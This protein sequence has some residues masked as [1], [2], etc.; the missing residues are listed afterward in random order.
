MKGI[1][2]DVFFHTEQ[3][4]KFDDLNIPYPLEECETR[5]MT[6][7]N[8]AS[9]GTFRDDDDTKTEYGCLHVNGTRFIST[10]TYSELKALIEK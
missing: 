9:I 4:S 2:I 7:Y 8:I 6:F 10:L 3:T 5:K 1:E